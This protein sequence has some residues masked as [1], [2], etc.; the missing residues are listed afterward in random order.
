MQPSVA[1][2][3]QPAPIKIELGDDFV[4]AQKTGKSKI[5][6]LSVV[7]AAI[8]G[9][10][11]FTLGGATERGK[12]TAQTAISTASA[13]QMA[14]KRICRG[15]VAKRSGRGSTAW[16]TGLAGVEVCMIASR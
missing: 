9:F 14:R 12:S 5:I 8:G 11:G 7:V 10:I 2:A 15:G 13:I 16:R 1:P 3:V 6:A 4:R